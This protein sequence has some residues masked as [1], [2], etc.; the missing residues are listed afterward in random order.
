MPEAIRPGDLLAGR[1]RLEV[2]LTEAGGGWFWRARDQVLERTV[3]V[4]VIRATDQRAPRLL[5]AARASAV[6]P[7]NRLLRVLDAE[8]ENSLCYVV[9]EWGTGTS[10][11]ILVAAHPL[12]PRRSAWLVAEVADTLSVAHDLG[13]PHGR[14]V[15]ENVLID[16][17]GEVRI[18]GHGVDAVLHGVG[19]DRPNTDVLD[20]V[21]LLYCA[22]TTR[23][24]GPSESAV[25]AAPREHHQVLRPRRVRAGVPRPLDV[26]CDEV[27]HPHLD[28]HRDLGDVSTAAGVR[29]YLLD[30]IG[31][32]SGLT[33]A[34]RA[35]CP[36][37]REPEQVV[38]PP[39]PEVH[40]APRPF[41]AP[42]TSEPA[43]IEESPTEAGLP[44][45]GD[46]DDVEWLRARS[47][48]ASPPPPFS[49]PAAKPLFAPEPRDGRPVRVPRAGDSSADHRP[50]HDTSGDGAAVPAGYWP[51]ETTHGG[52]RAGRDSE[53]K[54]S[55]VGAV[56]GT[57]TEAEE[58]PGRAW[59]RLGMGVLALLVLAVAVVVALNLTRDTAVSQ[60]PRDE[61]GPRGRGSR[62]S[63]PP[64]SGLGEPFGTEASG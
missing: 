58:V 27:L 43:P 44:I 14:L 17:H 24:A 38:L 56:P 4:H 36:D 61:E 35:S 60:V 10:L 6:V 26:L 16:R 62:L 45:F 34:L 50:I 13:V 48:P 23:W 59:L 64:T 1:Y 33:E 31:D 19:E 41:T 63:A 11:D 15:P 5:E 46:D 40:P 3:A 9:N 55:P 22:L 18:I 30:F 54:G 37:L 49:E 53:P 32:P 39:V 21:G 28:A 42:S 8:T 12:G 2:L 25:T 20:L 7:N 52:G 57:T 29:D 51:W 47:Q